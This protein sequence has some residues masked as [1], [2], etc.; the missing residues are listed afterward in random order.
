[1]GIS[2]PVK[3]K[4]RQLQ[5]PPHNIPTISNLTPHQ[6]RLAR[7][8]LPRSQRNYF[9]S[10][11]LLSLPEAIM[12]SPFQVGLAMQVYPPVRHSH[13]WA[14]PHT[15]WIYSPLQSLPSITL[16]LLP[17]VSGIF[18]TTWAAIR[19]PTQRQPGSQASTRTIH[20]E[21]AAPIRKKDPSKVQT[22]AD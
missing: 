21:S 8:S 15:D 18:S 22:C 2:Q 12:A 9:L 7:A 20:S 17:S 19:R 3:R 4:R 11:S 13:G 10:K 5:P 6:K 14:F 16:G 1:M